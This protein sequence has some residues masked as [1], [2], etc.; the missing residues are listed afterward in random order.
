MHKRYV[1][2]LSGLLVYLAAAPVAIQL[3]FP[4]WGAQFG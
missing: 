2:L 3:T 4:P 1:F